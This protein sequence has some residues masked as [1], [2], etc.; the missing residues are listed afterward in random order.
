VP[1]PDQPQ[2]I[3]GDSRVVRVFSIHP[4]APES[5]VEVGDVWQ[6]EDGSLHG[7]G[8]AAIMLFEPSSLIRYRSASAAMDVSPLTVFYHRLF[9]SSFF[10]P[11]FTEGNGSA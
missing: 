3:V 6:G 2:D 11:E 7:S 9:R 5:C 10:L 4:S 1:E 8:L